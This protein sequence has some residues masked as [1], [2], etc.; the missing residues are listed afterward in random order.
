[1]PRPVCIYIHKIV[2]QFYVYFYAFMPHVVSYLF[3]CFA[4]NSS[5][6]ILSQAGLLEVPV[7]YRGCLG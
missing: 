3:P 1:M 5:C 6:I 4:F 7:A 2:F